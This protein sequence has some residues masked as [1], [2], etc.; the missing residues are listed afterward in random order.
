MRIIIIPTE[1][2]QVRPPT[3]SNVPLCHVDYF[4]LKTLEA[5]LAQEKLLF[6][7][8]TEESELGVFP[9]IRVINRDK[10]YLSD[11]SE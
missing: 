3:A 6:S 5:L 7:F 1:G 8:N 9:R 10:F 11:L 4:D 2:V